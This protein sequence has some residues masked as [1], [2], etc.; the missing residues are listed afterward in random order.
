MYLLVLEN[1]GLQTVECYVGKQVDP[2]YHVSASDGVTETST[3]FLSFLDIT[4]KI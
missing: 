2:L 1:E 3:P 4:G